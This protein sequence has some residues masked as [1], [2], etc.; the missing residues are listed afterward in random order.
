MRPFRFGIQLRNAP[1]G[2][3][4]REAARKAEALGYSTLFLPDHFGDAWSPTVPLA[5]AAEVTTTLKVGALVYDNDYR[6]PLVLARDMA[7][8]DV[9]SEGRV[10]FGIGAGWMSSDYEQSGIALDS[11]GVRIERMREALE[12][13]RQLWSQESATFRG[14]HYQVE[15]AICRPVPFTRGGPPIIIGG[16]GKKVLGIAATHASIIGVNPELSSGVAGVEAARTAVADR[17]DERIGWIR[18]AAGDRFDDI[19]L[20]ILCRFEQVTDDRL[21]FA[22][23]I[24]P[25]FDLTPEAALAMP[26]ALVGTI[27]QMCDDLIARRERFGFS[28]IV[29]HELDALAPL[30]A[31]LA[32]T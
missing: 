29:V 9:L 7:A 11:P 6:H 21:G 24:A 13:F 32:G 27:D 10:E 15:G 4:W 18:D 19:E 23:S 22:T 3:S 26:I 28:Y 17:Y 30:V 5:V 20:Q 8:L 14:K 25:M 31:R 12:V 16:G 2:K 1:D